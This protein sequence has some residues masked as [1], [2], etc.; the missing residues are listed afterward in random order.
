MPLVGGDL[1]LL[2]SRRCCRRLLPRSRDPSIDASDERVAGYRIEI[3]DPLD[4]MDSSLEEG[5]QR[6]WR[7]TFPRGVCKGNDT[8]EATS[9]SS[10]P[11]TDAYLDSHYSYSR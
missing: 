9:T 10:C 1:S 11:L 2:M 7:K 8:G 4:T 3:L 5:V 6:K